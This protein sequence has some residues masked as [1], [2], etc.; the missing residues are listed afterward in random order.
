MA[1]ET[2]AAAGGTFS[3]AVEAAISAAGAVVYECAALDCQIRARGVDRTAGAEP[4][5]AAARPHCRP[6]R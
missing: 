4:A 6:S 3:A 5:A 1:S 2:A